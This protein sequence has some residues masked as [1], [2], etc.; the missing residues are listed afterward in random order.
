MASPADLLAD[1]P[2]G[3]MEDAAVMFSGSGGILE[4]RTCYSRIGTVGAHLD[5]SS[6]LL[7]TF[8]SQRNQRAYTL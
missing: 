4:G 5:V 1:T 6:C 7:K 8:M 2:R 3:W